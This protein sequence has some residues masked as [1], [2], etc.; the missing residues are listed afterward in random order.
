[1]TKLHFMIILHVRDDKNE[2]EIE[3]HEMEK[4]KKSF[5]KIYN[6]KKNEFDSTFDLFVSHI[7]H[8]RGTHR[9]RCL[10][11]FVPSNDMT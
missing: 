10:R 11:F 4:R 9:A 1:M 7:N 5:E 6:S 3:R 2:E 8:T